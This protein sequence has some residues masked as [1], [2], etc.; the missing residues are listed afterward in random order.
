[1]AERVPR[2]SALDGHE[3]RG[4]IGVGASGAGAEVGVRLREIPDL[5][6]HQIAAWP[7]SLAEVAS[8]AATAAGIDTAPAPATAIAATTD[9]ALL[10][11]EPLKWW[12]LGGEPPTLTAEQGATL[13][14]SHA[15]THLIIS[16]EQSATLLNRHLPLD[17]RADSFP[18]G[19]VASN[20]LHHV[21]VTLWHS[22]RGYELFIPRGFALSLWEVLLQSAAQFGAEIV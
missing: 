5:R 12:L 19:A 22:R 7:G 20:A 15:R 8:L 11:V 16:G 1:M 2:I 14:L 3:R 17:L 21:G 10:R 18:P 6:L 13:D 4:R 9:T